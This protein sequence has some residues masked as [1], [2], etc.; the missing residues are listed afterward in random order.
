MSDIH[1]MTARYISEY[2][3]TNYKDINGLEFAK[4]IEQL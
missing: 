2:I 1:H 4:M 3:S